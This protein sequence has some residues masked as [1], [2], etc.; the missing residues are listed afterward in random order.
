M[1][2]KGL[3]VT[4]SVFGVSNQVMLKPDLLEKFS[5]FA[6]IKFRYDTFQYGNNKGAELTVGMRRFVCAFVVHKLRSK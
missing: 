6:F 1:A 4:K 5:N 3:K 2:Y